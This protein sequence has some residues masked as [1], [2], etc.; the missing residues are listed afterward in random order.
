M[1][2]RH[3]LPPRTLP[4]KTGLCA[5]TAGEYPRSQ[6]ESLSRRRL[7]TAN[8]RGE[9]YPGL[10]LRFRFLAELQLIQRNLF[11][12]GLQCSELD[13]LICQVE[14]YGFNLAHLDIRQE[15]SRHE[16]PQ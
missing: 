5:E 1:I 4:L 7:A 6:P 15:S 11:E 3:S 13:T 2:A 16:E 8:P 10:P 12:T 14:I 9:Q